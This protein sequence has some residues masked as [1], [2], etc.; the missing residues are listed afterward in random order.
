MTEL[1]TRRIRNAALAL[2]AAFAAALAAASCTAQLTDTGAFALYYPGITDIGP[3]TNMDLSPSWHGGVPSDFE[4]YRVILEGQSVTPECFSVDASTG[5]FQIRNSASLPVGKYTVGI[6]CNANGGRCEFPEAITVNMMKAVPDGITATP[7]KI[8]VALSQ[9][10]SSSS[11]EELPT[12]Q[13]STEGEHISIKNYLI[14]SVRRDGTAMESWAD[15][16]S[17]DKTGKFSILRNGSFQSGIYVFDFKLT[18]MVVGADS[19]EGIFTDALTVEVTSPPVALVYSP[20]EIKVEQNSAYTSSAPAFTGSVTDLE[21]S[22][23]STYPETDKI[24]IDP[25]TGVITLAGDNGFDIGTEISVSVTAVNSYGT[26]DFDQVLKLT[27]VE[28]ISPITML[29][30]NDTTVWEGTKV[31]LGPLRTDGDEVRYSFEELP[32][33]ISALSIDE[34]TGVISA[35]KGN[36]IPL[37]DFNIKVKAENAKGSITAELKWTV[38][39]NPYA[40]TYVS[41]GN[42]LNLTPETG[43][44]SQH[45][46]SVTEA[47][48]IPVASSDIKEGIEAIFEISG[49]SNTNCVTVDGTSGKLTTVP[50]TF[51]KVADRRA[52]FVFVKVTTGKGT[53]GETVVKTPVFFDFNTPRGE[54]GYSIEYTPFAI[55]CNPKNGVTSPAPV[56]KKNGEVLAGDDLKN[57]TMDFRRSFNYWNINGPSEHKNGAPDVNKTTFLSKLWAAYYAA[58]NV[59]YNAGS[60]DP[61]STYGRPLHV[62]K[63][64]GYIRTQDLAL[65]IAPEKFLDDNGYANGIFT[66]QI[67]FS[68]T[69]GDPAGAADPYRLFPLFVWF[70]TRF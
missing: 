2:T 63:T 57:I 52:H 70:D 69:G 17:V 49:G 20:A 5:V 24:S 55:K 60:R 16:F 28:H 19:E 15:F 10:T 44:A 23:K 66:G 39:E 25:K 65:Y 61:I 45:R 11:A 47:Q 22:V 27:I 32:Q 68:P 14:S 3:S 48:E 31:R 29:A 56:I 59:A 64:I 37:G 18:T 6:A 42:N 34:I 33:S 36:T 35:N 12:A 30:Y 58:I 40:F 9:V 13:I 51:T 62:A 54:D 26:A 46:V 4:I 8:T 53:S 43:Y 50:E 1:I 67:T 38:I 7:D 21:F 41:W